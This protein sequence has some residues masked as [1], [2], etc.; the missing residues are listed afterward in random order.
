M[1]LLPV[2]F[3]MMIAI[4]GC[5]KPPTTIAGPDA[6]KVVAVDPWPALAATLRRQSDLG[7][8][9]QGFNQFVADASTNPSEATIPNLAASALQSHVERFR[10]SDTDRREIESKVFTSLDPNYIAECLYFRDVV[11]SLDPTGLPPDKQASVGFAWVCRNVYLQQWLL[12]QSQEGIVYAPPVP[13]SFVLRRGYGTGLERAYVF[14][15]VLQ[16][17]GF[18]AGFVG[19]AGREVAPETAVVDNKIAKGPFWAV[20]VLV[21]KDVLLFDPWRG[22]PLPGPGGKGIGTLAQVKANV[23]QLKP[24]IEDKLKP[25]DVKP[26]EVQ[27]STVYLCAPF[28]A[29]SMRMKLLEEKCQADVG[30]ALDFDIDAVASRFATSLGAPPTFWGPPATTSANCYSRVLASFLPAE[31]GGTDRT[32]V[33]AM[34]L[35]MRLTKIEPIPL[36]VYVPPAELTAKEAGTRLQLYFGSWFLEKFVDPAPREKIQRGQFGEAIKILVDRELQANVSRE[37]IRGNPQFEPIISEWCKAANEVYSKLS[38]ARIS[39]NRIVE[40]PLAVA[41][42]EEFWQS[43]PGAIQAL[44]DTSIASIG[45]AESAYLLAVCKHEQAERGQVRY[46][47]AALAGVEKLQLR[48]LTSAQDSWAVAKDAWQRY[49][50]VAAVFAKAYPARTLHI[51]QLSQRATALAADPN[52]DK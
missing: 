36:A 43:R 8:I 29:L 27:A 50:A 52:S 16:Q 19:V 37:R 26:A 20:G 38:K 32:P 34:Q 45:L 48:A 28:S 33:G 1:K 24:W 40:L 22:E 15:A 4:A 11:R 10:P 13:P 39:P 12:G 42:V 30:V 14:M 7:A 5:T 6:T 51:Q 21:G 23:E 41:E 46:Q 25:W 44:T 3:V 18:D 35:Y 49:D 17:L 2:C 31:E 47:K 9:R